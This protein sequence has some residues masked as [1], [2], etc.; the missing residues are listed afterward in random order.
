MS[1]LLLPL[2]LAGA[3]IAPETQGSW[4]AFQGCWSPEGGAAGE[5]VCIV[6]DG[7]AAKM[8]VLENGSP[9]SESRLIADNQA[10]G[11]TQ[12]GCTGTERARWSADG[13]RVFVTTEMTCDNVQRKVTSIFAI[14]SSAEWV[15][16]Q[17]VSAGGNASAQTIRYRAADTEQVPEDI[18]T[19]L[20]ANRLARETARHAASTP[21]TFDDVKE[22]TAEVDATAVQ[23]Y[24]VA[25]EQ[26][27]DVNGKRLVDLAKAGVPATVIDVIVAVSHPEHF[28][29][30]DAVAVNQPDIDMNGRDRNRYGYDDCWDRRDRMWGYG[31]SRFDRCHDSFGY[32]RYGYGFGYGSYYDY[33]RWGTRYWGNGTTVIVVRDRE[34]DSGGEVTRGG[35]SKGTGSTARTAKGR[36]S[37]NGQPS[38]TVTGTRSSSGSSGTST[39]SGG[40]K[41]GSDSNS[42]ERKA[43]PRGGN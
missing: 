13:Q 38:N 11:L 31:S 15:N 39:S 9:K 16:V 26:P 42:S 32:G 28:Q 10:R 5:I 25:L 37:N 17:S 24:I 3:S 19:A 6:P 8:I 1:A 40:S 2:L 29:I 21:I 36:N 43:K 41:S 18:R 7:S 12:E 23:A 4:L 33:G 20:A 30:S 35:Y 27:F 34:P 22:A 14:A